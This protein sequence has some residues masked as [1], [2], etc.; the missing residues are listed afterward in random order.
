[1]VPTL[2]SGIRMPHRVRD[3]CKKSMWPKDRAGV[4]NDYPEM[5]SAA[6]EIWLDPTAN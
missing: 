2:R 3:T 4:L 1:M 5:A 6:A